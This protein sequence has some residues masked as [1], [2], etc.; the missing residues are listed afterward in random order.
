MSLIQ[1]L[2]ID[3]DMIIETNKYIYETSPLHKKIFF[4]DKVTVNIYIIA[5]IVLSVWW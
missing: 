2:Y 5:C 3:S 4:C 1:L